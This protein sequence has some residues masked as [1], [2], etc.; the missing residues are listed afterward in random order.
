VTGRL[1]R[2]CAI[3]FA[4]SFAS[5]LIFRGIHFFIKEQLAW[6]Q[7]ARLVLALV[8]GATYV[9]GALLSHPIA[10]RVGERRLAVLLTVGHAVCSVAFFFLPYEP[11]YIALYMLFAFLN[12]MLWPIVE[13]YVSSGRTPRQQ[14]K[15]IGAFNFAWS[16]SVPLAVA[17]VGPLVKI[18]GG[19]LF[20]AAAVLIVI[21]LP[22]LAALPARPQHLAH[23]HPDRPT[24]ADLP[25]LRGYLA[26]SRWSML[27]SYIFLS[28][29]NPLFPDIFD[30]LGY[31]VVAATLLTATIDAVRFGM[32]VLMWAF[33]GWHNRAAWLW[34]A[35]LLLPLSFLG[36]ALGPNI[37]TVMTAG[38]VF[39]V[40]EGIAYFAALYYAVV[41]KNASVDAGGAHEALIGAGFGLGPLSAL[42]AM[43]F[44]F[45]TVGM[46]VGSG[47][48]IAICLAAGL[49]P[50]VRARP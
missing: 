44:A 14:S 32:F 3:T 48:V 37:A 9:V 39:G 6:G 17:S 22:M 13:S 40:V 29:L 30:R 5:I 49:R 16:L 50:L 2:L 15:A 35:A 10:Q 8:Y 11:A 45:P 4:V 41:V 33:S 25:T 38:V 47:P 42:V 18:R 23:D 43:S 31:G 28:F 27:A 7:T 19:W 12:A 46:L 36:I 26:S 20:I 21:A 24:D 34:A 1:W